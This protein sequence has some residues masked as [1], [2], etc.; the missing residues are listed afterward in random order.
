MAADGALVEVDFG[1]GK[2]VLVDHDR[3]KVLVL[4]IARVLVVGSLVVAG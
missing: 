3:R 1:Y 2:G 4:E